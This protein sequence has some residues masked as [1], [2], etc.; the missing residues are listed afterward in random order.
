MWNRSVV[1]VAL[2]IFLF[3]GL[4]LPTVQAENLSTAAGQMQTHLSDTSLTGGI[5][6][7]QQFFRV[8]NYWN[9]TSVDIH[10]DYQLSQLLQ[11][12]RS[13]VTLYM[14]GTPFHSFR[15]QLGEKAQQRLNLTVPAS[16]IIKGVN[17]LMVQGHLETNAP[18]A[19][20]ACLPTDNRDNWLQIAKSSRIAVNYT[21]DPI[22]DSIQDFQRHFIGQDSVTNGQIAI[23]VA[24]ENTS[25]ELEAATYALSGLARVNQVTDKPIP[26]TTYSSDMTKTKQAL[27]LVSLYE[28]LPAEV[29]AVIKEGDVAQKAVLQLLDLN[30]VKTLIITSNDATLLIKAGRLAANQ[31]LLTQINAP[32]KEV[33][34]STEVDTPAVNVSRTLPL[35][36]SGDK[37]VGDRHREKA[38]FI[39]LPGNRSIA[40]GSKL[41]FNFRY[42]RNVDFER[43]LV[44]ILVND[45]PIG[46]KRLSTEL[47]DGDHMELTIPKSL[48]ISGNFTVKAAFD[49]ELKNNSCLAN[50]DQMPWAF[51][52]KDSLLQLNTK[53][54]TELL[55]NNYPYPFLRDGSYNQVTVVLPTTR[56]VY[57]YQSLTNVFNLLGRYAQ[58]NTGK[59]QFVAGNLQSE[60]LKG[61]QIIAIGSYEDNAVIAAN[62]DKLYFRYGAGG[63]GFVSNEKLSIESGYGMR[64]GSL[65]LID[66]PYQSGFGLMAVTG[67]RPE[68]A[69]LAS[70]LI[71]SEG[72]LWQVFGDGAITDADGNVQAYRFKKEAASAPSTALDEVLAR[73][74]VLGFMAAAGLVAL[75]I[76]L[77]LILMIR[78][79][80][81]KKRRGLR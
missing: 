15:P 4:F 16:M 48:N 18:V 63:Q 40:D 34:A 37:L 52:E 20:N 12:E 8:E 14:N 10:L 31:T 72:S 78:K 17:T 69:Y 76:I 79:Y 47:A 36:E 66:S 35:T 57:L 22:Q 50:E 32:Q 77:S 6:Y 53:D 49:L 70:K 55:F 27:I 29:K 24:P 25:P 67:S 19:Q 39:S 80:A 26:L 38:Y 56:D 51:V 62:N 1:R 33:L 74:D 58:T 23:A 3:L 28:H 81:K 42:A 7:T 13:S 2:S 44:T 68:Y 73:K 9:V 11:N 64:I 30:G 46:S 65:Q 41:R 59:V 60:Q 5:T 75:L 54:R 45:T 61:R 21:S 43:S 71:G